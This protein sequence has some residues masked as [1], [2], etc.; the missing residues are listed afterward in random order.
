MFGLTD[1]GF[2]TPL[3]QID[4]DPFVPSSDLVATGANAA[5]DLATP[6]LRRHYPLT[7]KAL[8]FARRHIMPY[9]RRTYA[10]SGGRYTARRSYSRSM[11]P[12]FRK[13]YRYGRKAT[14]RPGRATVRVPSRAEIK[15]TYFAK[16]NTP[17]TAAGEIT[18]L[19]MLSQGTTSVTRAGS[20]VKILSLTLGLS[21]NKV[22]D[23]TK[24][25]SWVRA[26]LFRWDQGYVSPSVASILEDT[27]V[28]TIISPYNQDS[29]RNYRV[30]SDQMILMQS[31][32]FT[33]GGC[34]PVRRY[35]NHTFRINDT[36]TYTSTGSTSGDVRYFLIL[37]KDVTAPVIDFELNTST[38]FVDI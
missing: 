36:I 2:V 3:H 28:N 32:V 14:Y 8:S 17:V 38:R 21:L 12:S 25:N 6:Y 13:S 9:A 26:I 37:I 19:A 5:L 11:R 4:K 27:S 35:S 7:Y 29:A 30:I 20:V 15:V 1:E 33:A 34:A 31:T 24:Q 10:R 22:V 18:E 23:S 16:A